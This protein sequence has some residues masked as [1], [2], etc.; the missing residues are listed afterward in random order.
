MYLCSELIPILYEDP[1]GKTSRLTANLEEIAAHSATVLAERE[2]EAGCPVAMSIKD[3]DLYGHV[4]SCAHDQILGWFAKVR[5]HKDSR[6][7]G[8]RFLP[9]H[10]L[11]VSIPE[12]AEVETPSRVFA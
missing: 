12:P 5:L 7:S 9:E 1:S 4:E 10:F 2:L 11:A 3:N 8:Q 6:W